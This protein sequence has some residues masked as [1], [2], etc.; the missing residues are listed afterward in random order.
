[1]Q[2]LFK[3]KKFAV[4]YIAHQEYCDKESF[5]PGCAINEVVVI[6]Q[7]VYGRM[8]TGKCIPDTMAQY[9]DCSANVRPLLDQ[10]CSGRRSCSINVG[11]L[12]GNGLICPSPIRSYLDATYSCMKGKY[13]KNICFLYLYE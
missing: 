6:Q 1:M 12:L 4:L 2:L 9:L 8:K 10:Q 7:A 11:Q 3:I 5:S 13:L